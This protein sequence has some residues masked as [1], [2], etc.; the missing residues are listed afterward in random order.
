LLS[1][2]GILE[3]GLSNLALHITFLRPGWYMENAVWN[4][5]PARD[6]GVIQSFLQLMQ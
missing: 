4:L 6:T 2:L 3:Q 1:Q 5:K